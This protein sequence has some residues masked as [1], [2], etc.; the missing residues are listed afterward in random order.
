MAATANRLHALEGAMLTMARGD[1]MTGDVEKVYGDLTSFLLIDYRPEQTVDRQL[2]AIGYACS[3]VTHVVVSHGH[4]DHT[5]GLSL[6]PHARRYL[7]ADE[8]EHV[9]AHAEGELRA[10]RAEDFA[11][12]RS[13]DSACPEGL[14]R[15]S[16]SGCPPLRWT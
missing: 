2:A 6:F 8:L 15:P 4:F 9:H 5:G 1:L 14:A 11:G 7:G 3:D 13:V 12:L 16:D 10:C